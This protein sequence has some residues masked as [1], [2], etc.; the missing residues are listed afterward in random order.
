MY[1]L[2][3]IGSIIR[4]SDG[5]NIP[6]DPANTDYQAYLDWLA[7]GNIPQ[8]IDQPT[9]QQITADFSTAIQKRLDDFAKTRNYDGI[10]SAC[11][12]AASTVPKF[13]AEGQYCVQARDATW[14]AAYAILEEVT[15]GQ[16]PVPGSI[17]D[18]EADLPP[19][20]WPA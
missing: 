9:Q 10:L 8:P 3:T 6:A 2:T 18:F 1:R 16:R 19:L 14:A 20:I 4:T 5:A 15:T 12:Y 7:E 17:A 11:T 13:L